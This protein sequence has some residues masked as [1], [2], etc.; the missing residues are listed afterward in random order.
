MERHERLAH[1]RVY[2]SGVVEDVADAWRVAQDKLAEEGILLPWLDSRLLMM[3]E[4]TIKGAILA[5]DLALLGKTADDW[6]R[7]WL[8]HVRLSVRTLTIPA[9]D[10]IGTPASSQVPLDPH[11]LRS[12]PPPKPGTR[13]SP[14]SG[15]TLSEPSEIQTPNATGG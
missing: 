8:E 3:L 6:K 7:R 2:W 14:S 13:T 4:A 1:A 11:L 10:S 15:S 5:G 12:L 9:K